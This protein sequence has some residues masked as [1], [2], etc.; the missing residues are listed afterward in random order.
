MDTVVK[1]MLDED[2][3]DEKKV[4]NNIIIESLKIYFK[5]IFTF[6]I[7]TQNTF[8]FLSYCGKL[9]IYFANYSFWKIIN[10]RSLYYVK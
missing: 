7:L 2:P 8:S 1:S 4:M 3:E 9:S 5:N 6:I 10:I